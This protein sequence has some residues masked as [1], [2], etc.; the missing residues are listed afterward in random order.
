MKHIKKVVVKRPET[1]TKMGGEGN[2]G[3]GCLPK[4]IK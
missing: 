4:H 1:S 3:F 2:A